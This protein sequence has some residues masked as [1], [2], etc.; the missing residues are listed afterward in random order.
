MQD[1][2]QAQIPNVLQ[3]IL[4]AGYSLLPGTNQIYE[5]DLALAEFRK[6]TKEELIERG[7]YFKTVDGAE[8]YHYKLCS[9]APLRIDKSSSIR[10]RTFF[11][12]YQYKTG[13]ATHGL[14]PYRGKFHPQLIKAILNVIGTKRGET[15]LDPMTGSG[16]LNIEASI[17]GINSI[18]L[19]TSPFC[20]LMSEAKAGALTL[21]ADAVKQ[22][23]GKPTKVLMHFHKSHGRLSSLEKGAKREKF[24][25]PMIERL[26]KLCY[27]D[28]M[29]YARRREKKSVEELFPIV[30]DKYIHAVLNF[31]EI[32]ERLNLDLGKVTIALADSR[33][34]REIKSDNLQCIEDRSI[35]AIVTSP[36]YSFA[37][38][39]LDGDE[40]QLEFLGCD[41]DKLRVNMVGLRG[42]TMVEK[43]RNYMRDMDTIIGEMSRVLKQ[44][45][46]AVIVIGSNVIQLERT[47]QSAVEKNDLHG[48]D[49]LQGGVSLE[50]AYV[51]MASRHRFDLVQRF[52]HP[53][54]GIR[55]AMRTEEI[56]F[57]K[58]E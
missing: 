4:P 31:I 32:R 8:T 5:L 38:D 33:N 54:E 50:D 3:E 26:L 39:Y 34:M 18:G 15:I 53:I 21:D 6:L 41:T 14:F 2:E 17:L 46:Y 13:Y 27:L 42:R 22:Y 48:L 25:D 47:L 44:G 58:R 16:T 36:P 11:Q 55:N 57:F 29:G 30:F 43:V 56:L 35:D 37:I 1:I 45:K 10:L 12:A 51:R 7:A 52:S 49:D 20:C 9:G 28:A 23:E 19:D 40:S 24:E